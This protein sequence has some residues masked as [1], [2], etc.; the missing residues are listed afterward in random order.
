MKPSILILIGILITT[1][2]CNND[3]DNSQPNIDGVYLGTF[4]RNGTTANVDLTFTNGS[5]TGES[6]I[7]KFPA[8]CNGT[9]SISG[10][11]ITFENA[12]VWTAEFD[13]TLILGDE[14]NFSLNG[15]TVILT[16][17]SGDKYILTKQ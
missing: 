10:N 8:L 16:K 14:W 7:I 9:Y 4:E 12:C 15:N 5:W 3:D 6:E 1:L 11:L 2:A 17:N 13:W